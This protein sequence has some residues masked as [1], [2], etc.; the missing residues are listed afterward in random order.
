MTD[1]EIPNC[2]YETTSG[3]PCQNPS[4]GDDGYC[5]LDTHSDD[6]TAEE[7]DGRGAPKGND[8][9][10]GNSGGGAP[11][12]NVNAVKHSIHAKANSVYQKVFSDAICGIVDRIYADYIHDYKERHGEPPFGHEA[13]L[14]RIAV[15]YGKHLHSEEWAISKPGELESGNAMVDRETKVKTTTEGL[16]TEETY[17]QTVVQK[18]QKSLSQDRRMWLKDLGLL[19]TNPESQKAGAVANMAEVWANDLQD[20]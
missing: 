18:G 7:S 6:D 19:D 16:L 13:E 8:N 9:A 17:K 2:G 15:S 10:V 14:F 20:D 5:W 3:N 12:E 4:T 1:D 11:E